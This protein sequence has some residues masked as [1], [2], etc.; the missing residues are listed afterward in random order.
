MPKEDIPILPPRW[1]FFL[2]VDDPFSRS[3]SFYFFQDYQVLI[4]SLLSLADK[5][6]EYK[7][8]LYLYIFRKTAYNIDF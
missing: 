3:F 8:F 1:G 5:P 2:M 7:K 4:N 6:R